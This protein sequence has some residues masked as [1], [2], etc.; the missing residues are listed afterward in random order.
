MLKFYLLGN[1]EIEGI[2][3]GREIIRVSI[4]KINL[5]MEDGTNLW[6]R[7]LKIEV[8]LNVIF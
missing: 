8:Y 2:W 3:E 4:R 6:G 7:V 5:G 1:G